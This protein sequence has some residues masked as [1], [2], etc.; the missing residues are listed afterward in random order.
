MK[1]L[2]EKLENFGEYF[3]PELSALVSDENEGFNVAT[4]KIVKDEKDYCPEIIKEIIKKMET[5]HKRG[6]FVISLQKSTYR[7]NKGVEENI[8]RKFYEM[9]GNDTNCGQCACNWRNPQ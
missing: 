9:L 7:Y 2:T 1:V 4:M 5:A 8:A 3:N 6:E